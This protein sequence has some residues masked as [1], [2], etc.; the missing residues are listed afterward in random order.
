MTDF[1]RE[2]VIVMMSSVFGSLNGLVVVRWCQYD[3]W[4]CAFGVAK[5][6]G[7][8]SSISWPHSK[9]AQQDREVGRDCIWRAASCDWWE[10]LAGSTLFY[11]RWPSYARKLA[12]DGRPVWWLEDPTS[13][14]KPQ[15]KERDPEILLQVCSKLDNAR[16]KRYIVPGTVKNLT[17][18]FAV[19]KGDRDIRIVYDAMK[20]GLNK[21]IWVPSFILPQAEALTYKLTEKSWMLDMDLGELFLKFPNAPKCATLLWHRYQTL[22]LPRQLDDTF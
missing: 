10:W 3:A 7:V 5:S 8:S 19:T 11:W 17:T 6:L 16:M 15:P 18:Y 1:G 2:A 21:S 12:R 20:S 4:H 22:L 14:L 13:F 9:A